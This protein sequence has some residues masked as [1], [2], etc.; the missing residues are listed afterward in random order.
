MAEADDTQPEAGADG[1]TVVTVAYRSAGVLDGLLASVPS[2]T[3]V[4]VVDNSDDDE[5]AE[6]VGTYANAT[7][8]RQARNTGFGA[9]NNTGVAAATTPFVLLLNPDAR[10]RAGCLEA[11]VAAFRRHGEKSVLNPK[12]LEPDGRVALRAGSRFL[13]RRTPRASGEDGD[14]EID[15][16]SGAAIFMRAED[17]RQIGGFDE[18]IFLFFEDDD[19]SLR[20]LAQGYRLFHVD[21]ATV[22]HASGLGTP[23]SLELTRFK[24]YHWMR[25]YRYVS[26][27]HGHRFGRT[28]EIGLAAWRWCLGALT[29]DAEL[30]AKYAGRLEALLERPTPDTV[31]TKP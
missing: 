3:P 24:N 23:P 4:I 7:L 28:S 21:S 20:L 31:K 14:L 29:R 30:R 15:V 18:R 10:L 22:Q 6:L 27:K 19:L 13:G 5:T 9:G 1:V 11:L 12:I 16:L 25:S 8:I 26:A 2:E 17:Y